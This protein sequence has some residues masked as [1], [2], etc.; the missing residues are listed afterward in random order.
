MPNMNHIFILFQRR[1]NMYMFR[2]QNIT[3]LL[4]FIFIIGLYVYQIYPGSKSNDEIKKI[5][6]IWF[7][8]LYR[9]L[10][11]SDEPIEKLGLLSYKTFMSP[12][13]IPFISALI[14][15]SSIMAFHPEIK[16]VS[17]EI[18]VQSY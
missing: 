13:V 16:Q 11:L 9:V 4:T 8:D 12:T 17:R 2:L 14:P 15:S 3:R 7:I 18:A 10:G 6:E 5:G 1:M